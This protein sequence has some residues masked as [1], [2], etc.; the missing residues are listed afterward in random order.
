MVKTPLPKFRAE[1]L[2]VSVPTFLTSTIRVAIS[3]VQRVPKSR[4]FSLSS[5]TGVPV[6]VSSTGTSITEARGSF[7]L[8]TTTAVFVP[9]V[10]SVASAVKSK[11]LF[12]PSGT[13]PDPGETVN[14]PGLATPTAFAR[15]NLPGAT[16][17]PSKE[18]IGS[19]VF[20]KEFFNS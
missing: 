11:S 20:I 15:F 5:I 19:T 3:L 14:Q 12:S 6:T 1:T 18:G 13:E 10:K 8:S 4:D 9:A 2:R 7:V 17:L 16:I